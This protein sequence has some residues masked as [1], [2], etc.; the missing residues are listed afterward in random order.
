MTDYA[1]DKHPDEAFKDFKENYADLSIE[2]LKAMGWV[3]D[4]DNI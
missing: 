3:V 4:N 1:L 2:Q